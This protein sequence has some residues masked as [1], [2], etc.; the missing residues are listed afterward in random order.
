MG[1]IVVLGSFWPPSYSLYYFR[2]DIQP[3][4][5][6]ENDVRAASPLII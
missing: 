6:N 3:L 2:G 1:K 4:H 5:K